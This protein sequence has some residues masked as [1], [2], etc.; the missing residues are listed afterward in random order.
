MAKAIQSKRYDQQY[1]QD[2]PGDGNGY[3][4]SNIYAKAK[5]LSKDPILEG[6]REINSIAILNSFY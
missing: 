3:I 2:K 4:I 5:N 1:N 6:C